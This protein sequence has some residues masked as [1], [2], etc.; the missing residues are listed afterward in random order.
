[1]KQKSVLRAT[2]A[3]NPLINPELSWRY[4]GHLL[5]KVKAP[6]FIGGGS[7]AVLGVL[8]ATGWMLYYSVQQLIERIG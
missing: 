8:A 2:V 3:N 6:R 7:L 5:N 1:M 4:I